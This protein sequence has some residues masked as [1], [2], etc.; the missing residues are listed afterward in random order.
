MSLCGI[1]E[2]HQRTKKKR[3]VETEPDP[4]VMTGS[5]VLYLYKR[6]G[7][8]CI[9]FIKEKKIKIRSTSIRTARIILKTTRT[10]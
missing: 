7:L 5:M 3:A 8:K 4:I 1:D 10:I 6:D 9:Q 2:K